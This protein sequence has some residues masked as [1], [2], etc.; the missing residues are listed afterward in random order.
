MEA[1]H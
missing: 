1:K